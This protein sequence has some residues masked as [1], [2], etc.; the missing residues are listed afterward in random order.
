MSFTYP[1]K[2]SSL[3]HDCC[4]IKCSWIFI[5]VSLLSVSSRIHLTDK[6]KKATQVPVFQ[7]LA[8]SA[9]KVQV[10]DKRYNFL[11]QVALLIQLVYLRTF[12]FPRL[13]H[14]MKK[15]CKMP[16]TARVIAALLVSGLRNIYENLS[17]L[18]GARKMI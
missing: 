16:L 9:M 15:L 1:L 5:C 2:L 12:F 7:I 10:R 6:K 3:V 13:D 17:T 18:R 11:S 14:Y 4:I 8:I